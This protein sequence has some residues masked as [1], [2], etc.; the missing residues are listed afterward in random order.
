M[1]NQELALY[2]T[3]LEEKPQL[4]VL[5]KIDLTDALA[6]EPLL[7]EQIEAA[8]YPFSSISAVTGKGVRSMLFRVYEMLQ[9]APEPEKVY[10]DP[11]I[12]RPEPDEDTFVISR[13]DDGWRVQGQRI[14]RV[15]AMTYWEFEAT[16]R[17]FQQILETMGITDALIEAGIADGDIV[18]IGDHEL[19]WTE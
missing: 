8:G 5:N 12:I 9:E 10:A 2:N 13:L 6:W 15:A 14:E 7:R 16:T 4:V 17:R 19:E 18:Y 1:I 11:V 3:R